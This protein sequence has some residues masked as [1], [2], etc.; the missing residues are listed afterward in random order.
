[1]VTRR[2]LLATAALAPA[3]RVM[4]AAPAEARAEL[5]PGGTLRA[6]L[7]MRNALLVT[8]RTAQ[9]EPDGVA[10]GMARAIAARLGVPLRLVLYDS[11]ALLAAAG[12]T[13]A[14]DIGLVGA[15]PQ[16][17]ERIAFS[18]AYCE[19]EATYLVP[20]GSPI[21]AMDQVDRPGIRIAVSAGAAYALWLERN[22]RAATLVP[23]AGGGGPAFQ[24]FVDQGLEVFAGLRPGLLAEAARLPGARILD[25]QFAAVQQAIGTARGNLAGAAFLR[26]FVAEAKSSGLV[27]A[28]IERHQV[29][30]LSVAA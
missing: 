11:P 15:E 7:N 9:G 23:I 20:P 27:A 5:A 22:L 17:A 29:R 6:G 21:T 30:G 8:G 28:L 18:P 25:G 24:A 14:W 13:G 26:D 3:G 10:P 16:R 12:G 1:M 19:I 2:L 4:A